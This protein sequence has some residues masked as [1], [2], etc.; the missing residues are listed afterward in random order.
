[1]CFSEIEIRY[2]ATCINLYNAGSELLPLTTE[3]A[4]A[5]LRPPAQQLAVSAMIFFQSSKR[6]GRSML[7]AI[8][9]ANHFHGK[10][11][12]KSGEKEEKHIYSA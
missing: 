10:K 8:L 9:A 4:H 6:E 5:S 7:K 3:Q 11:K 2:L 12:N 1:M